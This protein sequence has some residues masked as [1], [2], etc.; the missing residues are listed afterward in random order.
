M[1][2]PF[3]E[4]YLGDYS[5]EDKQVKKLLEDNK[6]RLIKYRDI[7]KKTNL[8]NYDYIIIV[9]KNELKRIVNND[10]KLYEKYKNKLFFIGNYTTKY[11]KHK[12]YKNILSEIRSGLNI[13]VFYDKKVMLMNFIKYFSFTKSNEQ[14][15]WGLGILVKNKK[16]LNYLPSSIVHLT[17][18]CCNFN[19]T[20]INLPNK[21]KI[22]YMRDEFIVPKQLSK[23][24]I[25]IYKV[26]GK[27]KY[28]SCP[29]N[30]LG[31]VLFDKKVYKKQ[32]NNI[33]NN[34]FF[35]ITNQMV[36]DLREGKYKVNKIIIKKDNKYF[37]LLSNDL[38]YEHDYEELARYES[39]V[40]IGK[41]S[42]NLCLIWKIISEDHCEFYKNV[43][44][45]GSDMVEKIKKIRDIDT[46]IKEEN[47]DIFLDKAQQYL[48]ELMREYKNR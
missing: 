29:N 23:N 17:T 24:T 26:K 6:C 35:M 11:F 4:S 16:I 43:N 31:N 32:I 21:L 5:S 1:E 46:G 10:K 42:D 12:N 28:Y 18:Y 48:M 7:N 25:V 13:H 15:N 19:K 8:E 3:L 9:G 39:N 45:Y 22:L 34:K 37:E 38:R 44:N 40:M 30:L 2:L 27:F 41:M 47:V 14:D 33:N 20:L 36:Y